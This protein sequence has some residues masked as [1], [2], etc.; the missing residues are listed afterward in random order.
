MISW[1]KIQESFLEKT[2]RIFKVT[3][4][5]VKTADSCEP[6]GDDSNPLKGMT[7]IFAE[8]ETNGNSVIIGYID[9]NK[10]A[11]VGEKRLFSLKED[12][13]LAAFAWLKNNGDIY[14]NGDSDNLL[15]YKPFEQLFADLDQK[16]NA[17][18][19]KI[20]TGIIQGGGSYTPTFLNTNTAPVKTPDLFCKE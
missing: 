16:I 7:A 1:A 5:G 20:Q 8:S 6:F 2:F 17:E 13:S 3:Q 10:L 4:Y 18:L 14:L 19:T 12:G 11:E 9:K 15:K